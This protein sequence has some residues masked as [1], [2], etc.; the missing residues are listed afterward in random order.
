MEIFFDTLGFLL[1]LFVFF[2][3]IVIFLNADRIIVVNKETYNEIK[4]YGF[5]ID[6]YLQNL[7]K[8]DIKKR[9]ME[10]EIKK[11]ILN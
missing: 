3:F 1:A 8:D 6:S 11:H 9:E 4:K 7:I 10:K 5:N 2:C